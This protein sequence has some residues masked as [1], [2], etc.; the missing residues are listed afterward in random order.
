MSKWN[1]NDFMKQERFYETRTILWN[2]NDFTKLPQV[3][4]RRN[5]GHGRQG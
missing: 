2:K 3:T 5:V 1:K 4:S